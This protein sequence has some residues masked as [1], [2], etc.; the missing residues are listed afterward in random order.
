MYNETTIERIIVSKDSTFFQIVMEI[1]M[2]AVAA[3][4]YYIFTW[5]IK[6]IWSFVKNTR[7]PKMVEVKP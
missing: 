3:A 2:V 4:A 1:L 5:T 7:R 6:K